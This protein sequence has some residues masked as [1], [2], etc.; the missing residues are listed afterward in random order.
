MGHVGICIALDSWTFCT[1]YIINAKGVSLTS[2]QDTVVKR[3]TNFGAHYMG[4]LHLT[5]WNSLK[6]AFEV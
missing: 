4:T 1:S 2:D 6:V 5:D 3:I